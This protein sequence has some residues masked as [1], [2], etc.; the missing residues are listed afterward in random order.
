MLSE[1]EVREVAVD[2]VKEVKLVVSLL[3]L[4]WL[5]LWFWSCVLFFRLLL[6][7]LL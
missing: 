3:L 5:Q 2:V 6:Q 7:L 4:L 1:G